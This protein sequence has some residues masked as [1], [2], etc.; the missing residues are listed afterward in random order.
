MVQ[1]L[2]KPITVLAL[3]FVEVNLSLEPQ[4]LQVF[5]LEPFELHLSQLEVFLSGP[6]EVFHQFLVSALIFAVLS[7][8]S[9]ALSPIDPLMPGA[10]FIPAP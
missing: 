8:T 2:P 6:L 9:V 1:L 10:C 5:F 3:D 7:R 4:N